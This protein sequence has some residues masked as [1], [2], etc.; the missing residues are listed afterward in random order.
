MPE[1]PVQDCYIGK[2]H[3]E[4][5]ENWIGKLLHEVP[6]RVCVQAHVALNKLPH[7]AASDMPT[8]SARAED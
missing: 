3:D 4:S 5:A 7:Q 1:K 2:A 8:Q 6:P